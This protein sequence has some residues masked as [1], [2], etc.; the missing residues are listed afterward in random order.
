MPGAL[1]T[2]HFLAASVWVFA[3][4]VVRLVDAAS[5]DAVEARECDVHGCRP[6]T[7][8]IVVP[9][10]NQSGGVDERQQ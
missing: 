1:A 5:C 3:A 7:R 9:R 6:A 2:P 10:R 8:V 4:S